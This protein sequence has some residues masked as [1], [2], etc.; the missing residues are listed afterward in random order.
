[1]VA[2]SQSAVLEPEP[3]RAVAEWLL[4][5]SLAGSYYYRAICF[6][7]VRQHNPY[8]D[9]FYSDAIDQRLL[10]LYDL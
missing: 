7:A 9:L 5:W 4:F 8:F 2:P 1:M 10:L 6:S 3:Q